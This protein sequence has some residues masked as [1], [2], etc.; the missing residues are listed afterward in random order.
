MP[1]VNGV[2]PAGEN[3]GMAAL[4]LWNEPNL[5]AKPNRLPRKRDA[6]APLIC[7]VERIRG[8]SD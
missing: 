7:H 8:I 6:R 2:R 4:A 3:R 1:A 5:Q